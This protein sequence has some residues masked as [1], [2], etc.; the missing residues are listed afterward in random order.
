M[1]QKLTTILILVLIS[2]CAARY[3]YP[4]NSINDELIHGADK[5]KNIVLAIDDSEDIDYGWAG[6]PRQPSDLK[7]LYEEMVKR[8]IFKEVNFKNDLLL[9]PDVILSHYRYSNPESRGVH[10]EGGGFLCPLML[11]AVTLFIIPNYCN[12]DFHVTFKLSNAI[13]SNCSE[14]I[15]IERYEKS[16]LG[17]ITPLFKLSPNWYPM[18]STSAEIEYQKN[19]NEYAVSKILEHT[20]NFIKMSK[21]N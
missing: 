10:G 21:C 2:G 8:S 16:V 4:P 17:W 9:E 7:S 19:Y 12:T 18:D 1:C 20:E 6:K 13:N 3:V 11:T 5:L 14:E 15:E